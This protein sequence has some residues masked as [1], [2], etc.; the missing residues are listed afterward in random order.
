MLKKHNVVL[1]NG[2]SKN[3]TEKQ[4]E[5]MAKV[6]YNLPHM[7]N[8]AIGTDWKEKITLQTITGLFKRM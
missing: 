8:H 1:P 4:V 6:S 2:L 3:W 5:D 7:W